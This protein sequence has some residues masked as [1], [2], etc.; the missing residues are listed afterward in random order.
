M[1]ERAIPAS[2]LWEGDMTRVLLGGRRILLVRW[3]GKVRAFEDR[4]AHLGL[5][6]S[7]GRLK[8]GVITC[9]AH[10]YQY[11]ARTGRGI[12]PRTTCL[13]PYP[14]AYEDGWILVDVRGLR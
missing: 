8:E 11:D 1:Y 4:C 6:L 10:E 5:P 9:R 14:V 3:E 7:D 2:E 13:R 12:N